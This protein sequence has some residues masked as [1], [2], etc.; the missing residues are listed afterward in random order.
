MNE[1]LNELSPREL[2]VF[3]LITQG[4][5]PSEIAESLG[6]S[7]K[8]VSTYRARTMQKL[9][10][11]SNVNLARIRFQR[12]IQSLRDHSLV[13]KALCERVARWE[14]LSTGH[15]GEIVIEGLRYYTSVDDGIPVLHDI[16]RAALRDAVDQARARREL[17]ATKTNGQ[18]EARSHS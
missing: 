17:E 12:E 18:S 16:L 13:A 14:P 3:E 10:V 15:D 1:I 11:R 5:R 2:A 7:V 9:G 6:L 4:T 8:T